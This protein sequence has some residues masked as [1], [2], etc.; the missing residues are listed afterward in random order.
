M[1]GL[2]RVGVEILETDHC[3][4]F[5]GD[6]LLTQPSTASGGGTIDRNFRVVEITVE[7]VVDLLCEPGLA[8]WEHPRTGWRGNVV[9][10]PLGRIKRMIGQAFNTHD[11]LAAREL[12]QKLPLRGVAEISDRKLNLGVLANPE[13]E[14][15]GRHV[16]D[17]GLVP[18]H[19]DCGI[20]LGLKLYE[21]EVISLHT[22]NLISIEHQL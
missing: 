17:F 11:T 19:V 22:W 14:V 1:I 10:A 7:T 9:V 5:G 6:G 16:A 18:D 15:V 13:I 21:K 8:P 12:G 4:G 20:P 3:C 2:Q